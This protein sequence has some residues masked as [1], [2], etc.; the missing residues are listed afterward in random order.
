MKLSNAITQVVAAVIFKTTNRGIKYLIAR[1]APD[2][3]GAGDWEFPGGKI[4]PSETHVQA[5]HRE[6]FEELQIEIEVKSFI[7]DHV[8]NYPQKTVHL[9]FYLCEAKSFQ[10]SLSDHDAVEWVSESEIALYQ[11]SYG[12]RIFIEKSF[13]R[14]NKLFPHQ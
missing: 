11:F 7:A 13:S 5:L 2:Q 4:E 9:H 8:V 3:S 1:R 14:V 12:D 6:I 10:L